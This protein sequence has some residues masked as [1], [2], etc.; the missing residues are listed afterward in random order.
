MNAEIRAYGSERVLADADIAG[1]FGLE[2]EAGAEV[3]LDQLDLGQVTEAFSFGLI[4]GRLDGYVRDLRMID[5]EPVAFDAR[6]LTSPGNRGR[7]RISQRAVDNIAA[8]GG[9]G[10]AAL[11]SGFLRFWM[12]KPSPPAYRPVCALQ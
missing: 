8:L 4:T 12:L 5:W 7:R 9:G 2:I 6:L 11:S 10:A 3:E 1:L